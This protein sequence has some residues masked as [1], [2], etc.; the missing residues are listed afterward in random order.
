MISVAILDMYKGAP[1]QGMRNILQL[2]DRFEDSHSISFNRT[3]FDI[4]DKQQIPDLS[5]DIYIGSGGPGSPIDAEG[6]EP[7]WKSLM[8]DIIAHNR[9]EP[10]KKWVFQICHSFQLMCYHF[11]LAVVNQR[12]SESFGIF[13]MHHTKA[14][15]QHSLLSALPDPFYAVD[16]RKWQVIQPNQK[17]LDAM[18][19]TVLAI[20]KHR[21]HVEFERATMAI[22]FTP[23]IFGTQFHPEADADGMLHYLNGEEKKKVVIENYG[24]KKYQDMVK[25]LEDPTKISL[26][27][28]GF[29]PVFLSQAIQS[30]H[31]Q[32][33]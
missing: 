7:Q 33:A 19:A 17:A 20:E 3:I 8:L 32:L 4:R 18:G 6:W 27:Q 10:N 16:S 28:A 22:Q 12:Q 25:S 15:K 13:P 1:N 9:V 30:L 5:F 24:L 26:T 2:L 23:H 14:G 11:N 21:P 29:I 31:M